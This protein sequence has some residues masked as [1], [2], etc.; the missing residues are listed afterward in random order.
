MGS[1]NLS[2]WKVFP[3]NEEDIPA[4]FITTMEVKNLDFP[5]EVKLVGEREG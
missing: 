2:T 5:K 4:S 1:S 3:D